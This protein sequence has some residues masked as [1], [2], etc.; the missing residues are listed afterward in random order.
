MVLRSEPFD[1]D[2]NSDQKSEEHSDFVYVPLFHPCPTL[3]AHIG[4]IEE[5][6][7]KCKESKENEIDE[8]SESNAN[9]QSTLKSLSCCDI[10][11]GKG[12]D[13]I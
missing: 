12:R 9:N 2:T 5:S 6:L 11:C 3:K 1:E 8:S 13:D 4:D 7:I 10:G